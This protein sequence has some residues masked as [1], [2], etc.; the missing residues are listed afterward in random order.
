MYV[1][2]YVCMDV[3]THACLCEAFNEW[4]AQGAFTNLGKAACV[5]ILFSLVFGNTLLKK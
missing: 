3:L 5:Q 2:M 4:S 1:C